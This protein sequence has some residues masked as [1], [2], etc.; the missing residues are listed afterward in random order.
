MIDFVVV[1]S[2]L[3]QLAPM[4]VP[5]PSSALMILALLCGASMFIRSPHHLRRRR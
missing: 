4:P 3:A 2:V 1:Q 5:L